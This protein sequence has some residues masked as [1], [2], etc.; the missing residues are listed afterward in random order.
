ML[1][2]GN[3]AKIWLEMNFVAANLG[4]TLQGTCVGIDFSKIEKFI[5]ADIII[6]KTN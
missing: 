5:Y 4:F 1:P 6:F 3:L 2:W